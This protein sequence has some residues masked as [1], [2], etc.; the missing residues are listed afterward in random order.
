M[1]VKRHILAG[2]SKHL[3]YIFLNIYFFYVIIM[4]DKEEQYQKLSR[5]FEPFRFCSRFKVFLWKIKKFK[6]CAT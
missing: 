3:I 2:R 4:K 5:L 1:M 6:S